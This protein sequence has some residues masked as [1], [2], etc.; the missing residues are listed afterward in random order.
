MPFKAFAVAAFAALA[1]LSLPGIENAPV[2][3]RADVARAAT[4]PGVTVAPADPRVHVVMPPIGL[5]IEY[6]LLAQY[7]GTGVCPPPALTSELLRLGSPPLHIGGNSQDLTV[8]SGA[9][10]PPLPSWDLSTLYVLPTPF[11]T[12]LHCLLSATKEPL[13]AG[14]NVRS[15]QLA[16]TALM[17]AGAES[18]AT[19]GVDFSLGN[20]PDLYYLPNYA[21]LGKARGDEEAPVVSLYLQVASYLRQALGT[22]PV[23]GPEVA[24]PHD[25]RRSLPRVISSLHLQTVGVHLYPLSDCGSP[26]A[27]TVAR[28]LSAT[29]AD[30]PDELSW[31]V[32]DA[33]AAGLPA[34]ISEANSAAC[35][36]KAGVS[37]TPAA[38]VWAIRFVLSA[39]KVG[40]K[41]VRFHLSGGPYDPFIVHGTRVSNR[42]LESALAALNEWLPVGSSLGTVASAPGVLATAVTGGRVRLILDN[43]RARPQMVVIPSENDVRAELLT[44]KRAGLAAAVFPSRHGHVKLR[45]DGNSVLALLR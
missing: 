5:S 41:E 19:N 39:L 24:H 8:P 9:L 26:S 27:V 11:W 3:G 12:Q 15:G 28:L 2:L 40:F 33:D 16:W 21:S 30:A 6:P 13:T 37:D 44:P 7:L 23:L 35:G 25:W 1:A 4:P 14:I 34:V 38:G 31:V 43:E 45:L 32:A 36:G 17:A 22:A 18:A 29:S 10:T 42:P 20:E